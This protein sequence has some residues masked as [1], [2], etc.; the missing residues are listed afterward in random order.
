MAHRAKGRRNVMKRILIALTSLSLIAGFVAAT[1]SSVSAVPAFST[2]GPGW[3]GSGSGELVVSQY[4]NDAGTDVDGSCATPDFN[5]IQGAVDWAEEEWG[6]ETTIFICNGIYFEQVDSTI[7]LTLVGEHRA[8]TILDGATNIDSTVSVAGGTTEQDITVQ[9]MTFR[10]GDS[11]D[12]PG[13][14]GGAIWAAEDVYCY[15]STFTDNHAADEGGAIYS[16]DSGFG[17]HVYD[18]T[19]SRNDADNDGGAI[20]A[21]TFS[22]T[23]SIFTSNDAYQ[24]GAVHTDSGFGNITDSLFEGNSSDDNGGAIYTNADDAVNSLVYRTIFKNNTTDIADGDGGA[25]AIHGEY[26]VD[27]KASSFI[28]N[29]ADDGG[30]IDLCADDS[31]SELSTSTL[32][33]A[34]T[35]FQGNTSDDDGGAIFQD[36]CAQADLRLTSARFLDN[37]SH[38]DGGAVYM[39]DGLLYVAESTFTGNRADEDGG[40]I[41][42][43]DPVEIRTSTFTRNS[44]EDQ[45]GG[46]LSICNDISITSSS[47]INNL[48][49]GGGAIESECSDDFSVESSTFVGNIA[50][51]GDGGAITGEMGTAAI[52][53]RSTFRNNSATDDGGAL[54]LYGGT[55]SVLNSTFLGNLAEEAGALWSL[56]TNLELRGN[57]FQNNRGFGNDLTP[58]F[59]WNTGAVLVYLDGETFNIRGNRF[60]SNSG[61]GVGALYL[62]ECSATPSF[63]QA[64][65]RSNTWRS[66]RVTGGEPQ[67]YRD[68]RI[69]ESCSD[70]L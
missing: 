16:Q 30:A 7:G 14:D 70:E 55:V 45:E 25:I 10:N 31:D 15:N 40:A 5:T 43:D 11:S 34:Q 56:E 59:T 53:S 4:G 22:S 23:R 32:G 66:N 54:K 28:G 20:S 3:G 42:T 44:S 9:D 38:D 19:F 26:Y 67:I 18:C 33:R 57:L 13:H 27:L 52:I 36:D 12:S 1:P 51:S 48:A 17:V 41:N 39:D 24:G 61:R 68:V 65:I 64:A 47:F 21:D 35:L 58:S 2:Y 69:E 37:Y 60:I 63:D 6:L 46:A 29:S 8:K 62:I 49:E 50:D